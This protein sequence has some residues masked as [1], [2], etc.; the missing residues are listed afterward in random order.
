[1]KLWFDTHYIPI[2]CVSKLKYLG[3][4]SIEDGY[5]I[6]RDEKKEEIWLVE[7]SKEELDE[8]KENKYPL[9]YRAGIANMRLRSIPRYE[10]P[11][12]KKE[13]IYIK[14][15][16]I[17][18]FNLTSK[19]FIFISGEGNVVGICYDELKYQS[20]EYSLYFELDRIN[21]CKFDGKIKVCTTNNYFKLSESVYRFEC[22]SYIKKNLYNI[23][24]REDYEKKYLEMIDSDV[25]LEFKMGIGEDIYKKLLKYKDS[26]LQLIK[27]HK[28]LLESLSYE[29]PPSYSVLNI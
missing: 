13:I 23:L 5:I 12:D 3:I 11:N 25:S 20:Y 29:P 14:K 26:K 16:I 1:M 17:K 28:S 8:Y 21:D 24:K 4:Y 15:Q 9:C 27:D 2:E 22:Y 7:I 6:E 18:S 10:K 19:S